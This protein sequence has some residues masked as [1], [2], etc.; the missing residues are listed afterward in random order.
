LLG[1]DR[2]RFIRAS[3]VFEGTQQ[4]SPAKS[5]IARTAS[6]LTLSVLVL[7]MTGCLP[8]GMSSRS[9]AGSDSSS[10][11]RAAAKTP[12]QQWTEQFADCL[13]INGVR[14]AVTGDS[15]GMRWDQAIDDDTLNAAMEKCRTELGGMP[16]L[17][18]GD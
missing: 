6:A 7:L 13:Q 16:G 9:S 17:T 1:P 10:S 18:D 5:S 2:I 11:A 14:T 12:R 3:T 15:E 8:S 4:L